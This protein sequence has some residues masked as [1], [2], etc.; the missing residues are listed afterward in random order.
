MDELSISEPDDPDNKSSRRSGGKK[1]RSEKPQQARAPIASVDDC[2]AMLS[3]LP[4]LVTL[5]LISTAQANAIRGSCAEILRHFE[6]QQSGPSQPVL[7]IKDVATLLRERP[8]FAKLFEHL[9]TDEQ[10]DILLRG[11]KDA[12]NDDAAA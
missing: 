6:R 3:K 10:V 2:L 7:N 11:G 4:G 5:G 8:E 9:L 12:G 1:R